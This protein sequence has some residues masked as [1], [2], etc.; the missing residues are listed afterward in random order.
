MSIDKALLDDDD[1]GHAF[2]IISDEINLEQI[3]S[4]YCNLLSLLCHM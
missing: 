4:K 3:D 1:D 2:R